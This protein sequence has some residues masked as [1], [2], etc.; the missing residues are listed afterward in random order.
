MR[1]V[2]SHIQV[3]HTTRI[4]HDTRGHSRVPVPGDFFA[5]LVLLWFLPA[6]LVNVHAHGILYVRSTA[7]SSTMRK[8]TRNNKYR[9]YP[10][11][12]AEI[13]AMARAHKEN[14]RFAWAGGTFF[15]VVSFWF[16][17]EIGF[18]FT[19]LRTLLNNFFW[20]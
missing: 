14:T 4:Q 20:N 13:L 8:H 3:H 12:I 16:W 15:P 5:E 7:G 11:T 19:Y 18:G 17:R 2:L 10:Q 1:Y 6:L 9:F